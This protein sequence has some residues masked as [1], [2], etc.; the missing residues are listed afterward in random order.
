MAGERFIQ[1]VPLFNFE[2]HLG[3]RLDLDRETWL[4]PLQEATRSF[5]VAQLNRPDVVFSREMVD[6]LRFGL[7]HCF[8]SPNQTS[9]PQPR[10]QDLEQDARLV[11]K[12]LKPAST[13]TTGYSAT[14]AEDG[15]LSAGT[16]RASEFRWPGPRYELLA[17]DAGRLPALWR[18]IRKLLSPS[19]LFHA[20]FLR[21]ARARLWRASHE[22]DDEQKLLDLF[23]AMESVLIRGG[24]RWTD[25]G[26]SIGAGRLAVLL[27]PK[28]P[29]ER[30]ALFAAARV[31]QEQRDMIA[32]GLD[33]PLV[34]FDGQP[35]SFGPMVAD[36][37]R[38]A[39]VAVHRMLRLLFST[40]SQRESLELLDGVAT[41]PV[42]N[43]RTVRLLLGG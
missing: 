36:V 5:V 23:M 18:E 20:R 35:E 32:H 14:Y 12:I 25:K 6:R 8:Q 9:P 7:F 37:E 16:R 10:D 29:A 26:R 30:G 42:S 2:A 38:W 1:F 4:E 15:E 13:V 43:A 28:S 22:P 3:G 40:G 39:T 11:F 31:A 33:R 34:G 19:W 24:E 41:D 21:S 27:D 17:A